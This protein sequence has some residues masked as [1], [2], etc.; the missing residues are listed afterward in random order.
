MIQVGAIVEIIAIPAESDAW[1]E[2]EFFRNAE[3]II[4]GKLIVEAF[5]GQVV[6]AHEGG[7]EV[8]ETA[9]DGGRHFLFITDPDVVAQRFTGVKVAAITCAELPG[10][11]GVGEGAVQIKF[12]IVVVDILQ[13][14]GT[15]VE[16]EGVGEWD[17]EGDLGP[18]GIFL[19][20][21]TAK[22]IVAVPAEAGFYAEAAVFRGRG[23]GWG[24]GRGRGD[25]GTG[26]ADGREQPSDGGGSGQ[27]ANE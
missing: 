21:F 17:I 4:Q 22:D 7:V 14:P 13:E 10:L 5:S 18:S 11:E 2:S 3:L 26:E 6:G 9:A 25:S 24:S 8:A 15:D 20:E 12:I 1:R 19:K 23:E 27:Q 16:R